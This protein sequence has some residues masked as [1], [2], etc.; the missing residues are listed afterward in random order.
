MINAV[1]TLVFVRGERVRRLIFAQF[2]QSIPKKRSDFYDFRCDRSNLSEQAKQLGSCPS[3]AKQK[4]GVRSEHASTVAAPPVP[5]G[6]LRY[7]PVSKPGCEKPRLCRARRRQRR[8]R[9]SQRRIDT[10]GR[11]ALVKQEPS[12]SDT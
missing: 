8:R 7:R 9:G 12:G 1:I 11:Q 5:C 3:Q 2:Y 10:H 6:P 4:N